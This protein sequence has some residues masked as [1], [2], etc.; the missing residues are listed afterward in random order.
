MVVYGKDSEGR[1]WDHLFIHIQDINEK[2]S[3]T[4]LTSDVADS[5]IFWWSLKGG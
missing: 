5:E 2:Y 4:G 3:I 1:W